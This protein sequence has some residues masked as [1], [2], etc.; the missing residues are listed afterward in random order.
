MITNEATE[1]VVDQH[2]HL[3]VVPLPTN[4]VLHSIF[5]DLKAETSNS[6]T[7]VKAD[8]SSQDDIVLDELATRRFSSLHEQCT[9]C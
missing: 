8:P 4:S 7:S 6:T 9:V 1:E 5:S 2:N 3:A